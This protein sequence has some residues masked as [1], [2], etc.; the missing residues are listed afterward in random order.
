LTPDPGVIEVNVQPAANWDEL[1]EHTTTLYEEAHRTRLTTEKFMID[2]R[3][4]GTGGGNHIVLGGPTP[5]DSPFLRRPDFLWSLLAYWHNHPSL[6]YLF[7]GLF[8][9]PTS[10]A[11]RFDEARHDSTYELEIAFRQ[12]PA[13]GAPTPPWLVDRLFR[14]LLVDA[15]GNTHRAE[16]CID[17]MFS[18]DTAVGRRGLLEMRAFEMPPHARMSLAQQLLLRALV[19]RFWREPY[20]IR[21]TRWGTELHDRFML[22]YFVWLDFEDVLTE[23]SQ[24][25]YPLDL[26]WFGPHF[27]FRFPLYGTVA[28]RGID[29]ALR[30]A[31]EPWHVLGEEGA[32]GGTARFVDS[33]VE[34]MQVQV[35]GLTGDRHIVTC[36]GRA[37]PLHPTGVNGEFVAGVR[38]RAWQPPSALHP[39][40]PVHTPLTFDV[41]D[42]WMARSLGGC[43]YHVMHP[44][45]RNSEQFPVNSYEAESRRLARFSRL[46]HSPGPLTV[47]PPARSREFPY[48]LDLRT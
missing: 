1:V 16:F 23:L 11:P 24:R 32:A 26:E 45:G 39:T 48:T 28:A 7:S 35:T 19:A 5:A 42:T 21:L 13:E 14:N 46:A 43:Q 33:S 22:P 40:I 18:P 2:G 29:L 36:N 4:T 9:G 25:G 30:Q 10:Q 27:E 15:T 3:H 20:Q 41:V 44:G 38:Y 31:L 47:S 6:S 37:L 34:R 8:I 17:K 12:L